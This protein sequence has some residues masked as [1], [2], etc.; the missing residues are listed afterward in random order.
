MARIQ[1]HHITYKPEWTVEVNMLMHRT[2]S[3]IQQT[4]ATPQYYA[5]ITNFMHSVAHEWNRMRQELDTGL[6]LRVG[7][8]KPIK[9]E[10]L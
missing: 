8:D 3:R 6:D 1:N 10:K 9:R 7:K 4:R 2:V 5:D